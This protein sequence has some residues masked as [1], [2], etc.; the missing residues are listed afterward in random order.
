[1]KSIVVVTLAVVGWALSIADVFTLLPEPIDDALARLGLGVGMMATLQL[2]LWARI[3]PLDVA[4][5]MGRREERQRVI[6][7]MN[8]KPA[9][10]HLA[11]N[12]WR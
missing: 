9:R 11:A 3:R 4:Y 6:K 1:M 10:L 8:Q 12:D 2:M 7:E 5:R